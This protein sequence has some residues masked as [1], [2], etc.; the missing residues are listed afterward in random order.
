[1][2]RIRYEYV[3]DCCRTAV[4]SDY[5]LPKGWRVRRVL[6]K[7]KHT[8]P[9]CE[10]AKSIELVRLNHVCPHESYRPS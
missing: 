5:W 8:C 1:M 2:Q 9:D 3:C 4:R 10:S 7:V 6:N